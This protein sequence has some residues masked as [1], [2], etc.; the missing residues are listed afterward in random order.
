MRKDTG[1]VR[2]R[3]GTNYKVLIAVFVF[4]ILAVPALLLFFEQKSY[5]SEKKAAAYRL[6]QDIDE[7]I[8]SVKTLVNY[9]FYDEEF[10]KLLRNAEDNEQE[11]NYKIYAHLTSASILGN[12]IKGIWYF[13]KYGEDTIS[14]DGVVV[15]SD[16]LTGYLADN[17]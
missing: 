16:Y 8:S 3:L 9:T 7:K 5:L 2:N 4:F 15:G 17:I 1:K 11:E 12:M 10:Q 13:P 6:Q 14:A